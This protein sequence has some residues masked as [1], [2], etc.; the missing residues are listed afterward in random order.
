M[1][2]INQITL[3]E[4]YMILFNQKVGKSILLAGT[5]FLLFSCANTKISQSWVEPDN[6][7]S[8]ND[9]LIIGIGFTF[10]KLA[11]NS[12][13]DYFRGGGKMLWWMVGSTAFMAQFSALLGLPVLGKPHWGSPLPGP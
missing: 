9:L 11:K 3:K 5:L 1:Q 7:K 12:T 13:S 4:V 8:Y 6:T 10:K 2:A